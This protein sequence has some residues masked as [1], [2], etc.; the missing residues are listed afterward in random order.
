MNLRHKPNYKTERK[1]LSL[2]PL[3]G[4]LVL[5]KGLTNKLHCKAILSLV[6]PAEAITDELAC[7]LNRPSGWGYKQSTNFIHSPLEGGGHA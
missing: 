4:H 2:C 3:V 5:L 1:A 7:L 6:I